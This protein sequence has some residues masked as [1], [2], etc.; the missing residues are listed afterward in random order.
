MDIL[1]YW[2]DYRQN[3]IRQFAG[4]QAYYWHSNATLLGD[5]TPGVRLWM[6]TSGKCLRQ[7]AEQAGFLVAVW[8]VQQVVESPDDDPAYPAAEYKYR[9][10]ANEVESLNLDEPVL[11]DHP[12]A[13]LDSL[14]SRR[15]RSR[16]GPHRAI[17]PNGMPPSVAE[18][19]GV[20]TVF[21]PPFKKSQI[22]YESGQK[23]LAGD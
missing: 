21:L 12:D 6:V 5:L 22:S 11:V 14:K 20:A 17:Y 9:V 1:I 15:S 10:I 3:W 23:S 13:V 18:M 4:E 7:E 8:Q 19:G 16:P 2:R